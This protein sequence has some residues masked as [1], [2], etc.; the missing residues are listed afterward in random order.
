MASLW[1]GLSNLKAKVRAVLPTCDAP[2][3]VKLLGHLQ[4]ALD[5]TTLLVPLVCLQHRAGNVVERATKLLGILPG[6]FAV[7]KILLSGFVVRKLTALK[8]RVD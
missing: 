6:S 1:P 4:A 8:I 3:N 2:S 7:S 5:P